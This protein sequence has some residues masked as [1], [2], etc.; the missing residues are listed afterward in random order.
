M[1]LALILGFA[2]VATAAFLYCLRD[3]LGELADRRSLTRAA[4]VVEHVQF[5]RSGQ[6]TGSRATVGFVDGHGQQRRFTTEWS[7]HTYSE[8]DTLPVGYHATKK[9]PPRLLA[10]RTLAGLAALTAISGALLAASLFVIA[11][12]VLARA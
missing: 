2:L 3:L 8:G 7:E 10:T 5:S 4:G 6:P 9:M 1:G 11:R 12:I